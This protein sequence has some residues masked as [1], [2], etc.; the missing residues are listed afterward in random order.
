[1]KSRLVVA[2][3]V[4]TSL[5]GPVAASEA[6]TPLFRYAIDSN[7]DF[8][9]LT[10][11][12]E[13]NGYVVLQAW[14]LNELRAIK[15][16][17]PNVKVLVYK[18]LSFAAT[19][20]HPTGLSSTGVTLAEAEAN[21][22]WFLKNTSGQR[23]SSGGYSWLW[24]MD[25]GN[26]DYQRRWAD[27]VVGEVQRNGWDGV[28]LDDVN[29]TMK[30]HY[31]VA[32]VAKYPSDAAYSAATRSALAQIGPRIQATGK[33]AIA[34]NACWVEYFSTG[35][36]WLQFLS[37]AMDEM[38][39]K[40][41]T[42]A[43][44]GY[45]GESQWT[46]QLNELKETQRQGKVFIGKTQSSNT[47]AAAARYGFAT[48]L[49]GT[50]GNAAFSFGDHT[51]ETPIFP[52][53]SLAIGT[54]AA[55]EERLSNGVHRRAFSSGQVL[56]NP[57]AATQSVSLGA[58]YSGSGLTSVSSVT[59]A[60]QTGLILKRD[61]T[62][63][64]GT[65]APAPA[66]E[67]T[68]APNPRKPK[69]PRT[70]LLASH[71]TGGI[72]TVSL[73]WTRSAGARRYAVVRGGRRVGITRKR[74]FVDRRVRAGRRYRYRVVAIGRRGRRSLP[75]R[76][77]RIRVRAGLLDA[78]VGSAHPRRW[79]KARVLRLVRSRAGR[80]WRPAP[81]LRARQSGVFRVVARGEGAALSTRVSV[82]RA[83]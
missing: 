3:A 44:Q 23:F 67:P 2:L 26:P 34:N 15:A 55:A 39:L 49:L 4:A 14:R 28:L 45:R 74:S 56:V 68:P 11:T 54:P 31:N 76:A 10:R 42:S 19:N 83:S 66:P 43:G 61:G 36:D 5:C 51:V 60:P 62:G 82:R 47:D 1:M 17:D 48:V 50:Q 80:V 12:A 58:A 24:A 7:P 77:V 41:S 22:D 8:T 65:P 59:M 71:A 18:N 25:V 52:E 9:N 20:A 32:S 64:T 16:A 46:T 21:P 69:K 6:A 63:D 73:T 30:Y 70:L 79:S 38:F 75:S 81:R 78:A 53:Y 72:G 27:N 33:L 57:T 40:W 35:V 13:R 37:G 29:P